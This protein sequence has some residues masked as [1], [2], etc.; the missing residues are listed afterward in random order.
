MGIITVNIGKI[1]ENYK[2]IQSLTGDG[3]EVAA[4]VKANAYG[5]GIAPVS[6]ALY[7]QGARQFFVATLPEGLELRTIIGDEASIYVLNG[8]NP[9]YVALYAQERIAPI[10]NSVPEIETY[11]KLCQ[12]RQKNLPAIIHIDTGMNRLGLDQSE[13]EWLTKNQDHLKDI[14]LQ[15][16]MSHFASSDQKDHP[17]NK[18]QYAAFETA[19][20]NFKNIK[21]SL[22]NSSGIF[23]TD[24]YHFDQVR[25]GMCL[26]GLNPTPEQENPMQAALELTVPVLQVKE[27]QAGETCGYNATYR[28]EKN[29]K[30][31]IV[32][33]GYADGFLRSL[34]NKGTLY[35]KNYAC[36]VRGRVSMDL[37][38][39][40]LSAIP[41]NELPEPGEH[42]EVFGQNQSADDLAK[43]CDT[44]GYEMLTSLSRRHKRLYIDGS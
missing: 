4:V 43:A 1:T 21:K 26:Y 28:F 40:D 9:E 11:A 14:D 36:P 44:I 42:I 10:L 2:K 33:N 37:T 7:A 6:E 41:E 34:S 22:A 39:I 13:R 19:S 12:D 31:A 25:P 38:I 29:T 16:V 32:P 17:M 15:Y 8:L 30:L 3:C 24:K 27:A 18:A 23:R 5:C 20:A 35:W